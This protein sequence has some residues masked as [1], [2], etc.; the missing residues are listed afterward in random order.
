MTHDQLLRVVARIYKGLPVTTQILRER[1]G[2]SQAGA[3]RV[4]RTLESA[5]P[6]DVSFDETGKRTLRHRL[7]SGRPVRTVEINSTRWMQI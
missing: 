1:Y 3:K 5:L 7:H 2:C 4:M 6:V